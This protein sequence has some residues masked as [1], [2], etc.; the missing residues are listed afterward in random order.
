MLA[1]IAMS[2]IFIKHRALDLPHK[3]TISY[4]IEPSQSQQ[5]PLFKCY[6]R[7]RHE[8]TDLHYIFIKRLIAEILNNISKE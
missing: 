7:R 3:R 1:N 8:F 4:N 6:M 5:A 2:T